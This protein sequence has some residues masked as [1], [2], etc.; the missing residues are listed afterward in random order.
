LD[1][2]DMA[3]VAS[4]SV[5]SNF[6]LLNIDGSSLRRCKRC[7]F[8]NVADAGWCESCGVALVANPC[9]SMDYEIALGLKRKFD[10]EELAYVRS[11]EEQRKPVSSES[12]FQRAESLRDDLHDF[13]QAI[14]R[15]F[16]RS[17]STLG[18]LGLNSLVFPTLVDIL[19]LS[20]PF[21][22][23]ANASQDP[24]ALAYLFDKKQNVEHILKNGFD[25][26]L[27]VTQNMDA[28]F[29]L[30]HNSLAPIKEDEED[31]GVCAD[32]VGFIVAITNYSKASEHSVQVGSG[33]ATIISLSNTADVLPLVSFD[34]ATRKH[35]IIRRLLNGFSRILNDFFHVVH[36][37]DEAENV[38]QTNEALNP[39]KRMKQ[40]PPGDDDF[41]AAGSTSSTLQALNNLS[42][43]RPDGSTLL[44]GQSSAPGESYASSTGCV[45]VF[46]DKSAK[47]WESKKT[48]APN[49]AA[50]DNDVDAAWYKDSLDFSSRVPKGEEPSL[51]GDLAIWNKVDA[52]AALDHPPSETVLRT[53]DEEP[54][55]RKGL[56]GD[57]VVTDGFWNKVDKALEHPTAEN[58][59][60][61][62]LVEELAPM[63]GMTTSAML[64]QIPSIVQGIM[65]NNPVLQLASTRQCHLL[66]SSLSAR[67]TLLVVRRIID[68]GVVG[69]LVAFLQ[70][71]E[72]RMLRLESARALTSILNADSSVKSVVIAHGAVSI[73][74]DVLSNPH[75]IIREQAIWALGSIADGSN[76]YRDLVLHAGAMEALLCQ[77]QMNSSPL[78]LRNATWA[79]SNLCRG[80]PKPDF[81]IL[82]ASLPLLEH[83]ILS[84]SDQNILTDACWALSYLSDGPCS[85]AQ[86]VVEAG[87]GHRLIDLLSHPSANVQTPALRTLGNIV[88]ALPYFAIENNVLL[89]FRALL[90]SPIRFIRQE[91]CWIVSNIAAGNERQIQTI[92][93]SCIIPPLLQL[94][95]AA[96]IEIRKE[97]TCAV[98][99]ILICGS[100][101]QTKYVV[102]QGCIPPLCDILTVNEPKLVGVALEGL[103]NILKT[104]D[105]GIQI[106]GVL[107]PMAVL[108]SNAGG[109]NKIDALNERYSSDD[110]YGK[111]VRDKSALILEKYFNGKDVPESLGVHDVVFRDGILFGTQETN[112][113]Y[114][115]ILKE[116]ANMYGL[117]TDAS[118]KNNLILFIIA[119]LR[120]DGR[121]LES[122]RPNKVLRKDGRELDD[123]SSKWKIM[124]D[125]DLRL[126]VSK[127]LWVMYRKERSRK[128]LPPIK[129]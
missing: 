5:L 35:D 121:V 42:I 105:E 47:R 25:A 1:W 24:V 98:A 70:H 81:G 20:C 109:L 104:G 65:G 117:A 6:D 80:E 21:I 120:Q 29:N 37:K 108:I 34:A 27:S 78:A 106:S 59:P 123:S 9:L 40:D 49:D 71:S 86:A 43:H 15:D 92:L 82:Q 3:S 68:A 53:Q 45:Q 38:S 69:H 102:N 91:V 94:S 103:E 124:S 54:S 118:M 56:S 114:D 96:D 126:Q 93:D 48:L 36:I 112:A 79:L 66:L 84:S 113:R 39:T 67:E 23:Q 30:E 46:W 119:R 2:Q 13:A 50:A 12:L 26:T 51:W 77:W 16:A 58:V 7:T 8:D 60:R 32:L 11:I 55:S 95:S 87:V 76:T 14:Q 115:S 63:V 22:S 10:E 83:L 128:K 99:N 90:S 61:A 64:S 74:V 4:S 111:S 17:G 101:E 62:H 85:H 57:F 52:D 19:M 122:V 75:D 110:I 107:N 129:P 116:H 100:I 73:F 33:R 41:S 31:E 125:M 44:S 28:A 89:H 88:T 127:D 72:N 18:P 97:A